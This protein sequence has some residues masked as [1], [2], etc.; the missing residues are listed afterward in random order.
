M[1]IKLL[2]DCKQGQKDEV[3]NM[4]PLFAMIL[5]KKGLAV[6]VEPVFRLGDLCVGEIAKVEDYEDYQLF[7]D[8]KV[9]DIAFWLETKEF[10]VFIHH[11][12]RF[13]KY[14]FAGGDFYHQLSTNKKYLGDNCINNIVIRKGEEV[15]NHTSVKLLCYMDEELQSRGWDENTELTL[16]QIK[17]FEKDLNN[18]YKYFIG[19]TRYVR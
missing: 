10:A 12:P 5:I 9:S 11:P 7:E 17:Q 3:V 18:K 4:R 1:E 13:I 15:V 19:A 8:E 6:E 16:N 2:K 14:V